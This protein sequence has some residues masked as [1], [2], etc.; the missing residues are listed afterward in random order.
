MRRDVFWRDA[1]AGRAE[2]NID[3]QDGGKVRARQSP[4]SGREREALPGI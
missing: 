3:H 2:G 4:L 1:R